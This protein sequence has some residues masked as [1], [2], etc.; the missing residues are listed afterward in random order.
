MSPKKKRKSENQ[1]EEEEEEAEAIEKLPKNWWLHSA[2]RQRLLND[3]ESGTLS[4]FKED[5]SPKEAWERYT[6]TCLNLLRSHI[7]SL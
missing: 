1:E 4:L 3:L 5:V 6:R 7:R 2:A